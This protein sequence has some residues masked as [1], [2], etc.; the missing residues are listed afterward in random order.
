MAEQAKRFVAFDFGAES[1]RGMLA[2]LS[3][4]RLTL[5]ELRRWPNRP[6]VMSGTR[7]WDLPFLWAEMVETL[8]AVAEQ[9]IAVD[10]IGVDTWGVDF[11]LLGSDGKMIG[12]PVQYR[13]SRT[14]NIHAYSDPTL[15]RQRIFELTGYEPWPLASLFQLLAMQ[16]DNSPLLDIATGLLNMPDLLNYLLTGRAVSERS[17]ANTTNLMGIDGQWC[18]EIVEAFALP[19]NMLGELI[20]P[21]TV[22]GPL[23]PAVQDLT[24]LGPVPV[25]AVCGHDTSAALAAVPAEGDN[26]AF[27]SC[28]T[29]SILGALVDEPVAT[30]DCLDRGFTNEYTLGGWYLARNISG[31]WLVQEL[32]RQWDSPAD[33][34][35][36]PRM[37]R[38]A[39][40]DEACRYDGLIDV[41]DESLLA[42]D[43]MEAALTALL[44]RSGQAAPA[45]R[46]QLI[47]SVLV[48]LALEYDA[49]L[50]SMAELTGRRYD[51]LYL[52]GGGIA[53]TLLCQFT[54][55]ACGLTVTAGGNECTAMGNA[56]IQARGLGLLDDD[57]AIRRVVRDSVELTEYTPSEPDRWA[58][59]RQR[60]A[61]LT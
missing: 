18:D 33:P 14:E 61:T 59:M 44:S 9:G 22:L 31:L 43:D 5:T 57:Q 56:L 38:E 49:R 3:G 45:S 35:D 39:M 8:Q 30:A 26:W 29:W 19:R 51:A 41:A 12:L 25:V 2:E 4:G 46:G 58:A 47:R 7:H 20:E 17:I 40:T 21:G 11:G 42:P 1:G 28:G 16:R 32:R 55:D 10:A 15:D 37:T 60:Y 13:D 34:W 23:S 27:I 48:S 50:R 53:N 36:Y 54:A 24:G 52:V 6:S